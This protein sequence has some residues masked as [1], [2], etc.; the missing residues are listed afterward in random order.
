MDGGKFGELKMIEGGFGS[1]KE[2]D[3]KNGFFN[4]E[5]G[6]G[7]LL[8]IASYP[9]CFAGAVLSAEPGVVACRMDPN[10]TG[11]DEQ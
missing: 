7:G 11:V 4:G 3:G 9:L 1:Y 8:H 6:G 2:G 10:S 5:L